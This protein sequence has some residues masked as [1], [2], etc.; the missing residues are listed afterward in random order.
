MNDK[1]IIRE[2]TIEEPRK[3]F[4]QTVDAMIQMGITTSNLEGLI[5]I[6]IWDPEEGL[7]VLD[8]ITMDKYNAIRLFGDL[9]VYSIDIEDNMLRYTLVAPPER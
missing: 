3:N 1:N 7:N 6:N 4:E 9:L 8:V 5:K 2:T